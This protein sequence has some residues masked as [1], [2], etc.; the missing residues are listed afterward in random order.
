MKSP[1][2]AMLYGMPRRLSAI[3]TLDNA[4]PSHNPLPAAECVCTPCCKH[5]K[6]YDIHVP[7]FSNWS[8]SP[9]TSAMIEKPC[10]IGE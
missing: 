3:E 1:L 9:E 7:L 5:Q 8:E 2:E 4:K 10:R 6:A